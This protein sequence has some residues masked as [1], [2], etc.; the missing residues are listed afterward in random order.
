MEWMKLL[1]TYLVEM[2]VFNKFKDFVYKITNTNDSAERNVKLIQDFID[3]FHK[4]E[5]RQDLLFAVEKIRKGR[6]PKKLKDV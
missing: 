1:P 3:S 4:E 2:S 6:R 5:T